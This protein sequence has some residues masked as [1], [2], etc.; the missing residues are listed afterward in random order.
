MVKIEDVQPRRSKFATYCILRTELGN[1]S[2]SERLA[3]SLCLFEPYE[4]KGIV[5]FVMG[6]MYLWV[7]RAEL[8]NANTYRNQFVMKRP[9]M[10]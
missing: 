1:F 10:R 9:E 6:G 8:F 2:C 4:L 5:K 7:T 3:A